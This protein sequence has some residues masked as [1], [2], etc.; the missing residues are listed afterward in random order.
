MSTSAERRKRWRS[1]NSCCKHIKATTMAGIYVLLDFHPYLDNPMF[2]RTLKDIAQ[3]YKKCARTLVL[4]SHEVKLPQEL[5][6]LAARFSLRMP[7]KNERHAIVMQMAREW[8]QAPRR[9]AAYRPQGGRKAGRQSRRPAAARRR[10]PHAPGHLQRRRAHRRRSQAA[11]GGQVSAAQSRRHV[12]VRGGYRAL[13]RSGRLEES[14]ALDP[15]AQGGVRRHGARR[16]MR[17]RAC[18]C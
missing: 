16:W 3:E 8:A 1:P 17:P 12:V 9:D 6:H 7:D 15:A 18:C 2:V 14:A 4:I 11:A 10:A 13:R 5:E